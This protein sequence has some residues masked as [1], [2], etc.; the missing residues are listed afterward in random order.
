MVAIK[1][2]E[3]F[4]VLSVLYFVLNKDF[5]DFFALLMDFMKLI[6]VFS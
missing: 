5:T 6:I 4:I 1:K 3:D 2:S